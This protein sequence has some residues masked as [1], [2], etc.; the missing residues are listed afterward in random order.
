MFKS[1]SWQ[2]YLLAVGVLAAGYYLIVISVFYS[3]DILSRLKGATVS[4]TK[5]PQAT[6]EAEAQKFMGAISNPV[7]KKIPLKQSISEGEE[8]TFESDPEKMLWAQWQDSSASELIEALDDLFTTLS[9]KKSHRPEYVINIR[10]VFQ[11]YPDFNNKSA[12][13]DIYSFIGES[14]KEGLAFSTEE[15]ETLWLDE[16]EEVI[17]QSTTKNNYEK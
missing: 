3:R 5:A 15:L 8:L 17:Y 4:K 10:K 13:Q 1:I 12:K 9:I 11:A 2:D 16:N 7:K 6:P 14:L